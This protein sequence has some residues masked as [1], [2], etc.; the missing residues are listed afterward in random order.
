MK[1]VD[2]K[3]DGFVNELASDSPAPGGGSVAALCGSLGV[4]LSEMVCHLTV[5]KKKY[6][7]NEAEVIKIR[8]TVSALKG[9]LLVAIDKD[10]EAFNGVSA[11]FSMPKDTDEEKELRKAAMQS[12]LKEA[13]IVPFEVMELCY[14]GLK[15]IENAVSITNTNCAS[16][17]G[18][19][20][21]TLKTG[22]Q[23]AY[24]NVLINISG[25]KDEAFVTEYKGKIEEVYNNSL[26]IADKVYDEVLKSL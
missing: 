14:E 23:G 9:K 7:E 5:G 24:L 10:T 17:L 21:L 12:A 20:A 18:V 4:A 15:A 26:K 8:E 22:V 6:E 16:D 3:V 2:L 11:V 1:L 19:S 13:T 25:I